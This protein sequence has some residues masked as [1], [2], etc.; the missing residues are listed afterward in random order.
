MAKGLVR[1]CAHITGGG[2]TDNVDRILPSN[3]TA[4]IDCKTWTPAPIFKWL[5]GKGGVNNK[6][7]YRTFNM[8]I[9][10]VLAVRKKD[11][12]ALLRSKELLKFDPTII[13]RVEAGDGKVEMT[14]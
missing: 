14:Y 11:A 5:Q 1:G 9:G 13:G 7:M 3:C 2:F 8:G 10:M 6:E 12:G 4:A